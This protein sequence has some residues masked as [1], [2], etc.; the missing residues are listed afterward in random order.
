MIASSEI[1][2]VRKDVPSG[3]IILN[4]PDRRNALSSDMV[5]KLQEA[6]EDLH[7]ERSVR[8]IIL[9]GTENT[10]CAGTDL[11]EMSQL[12]EEPQAQE[13]WQDQVADLQ[14]LIEFMLRFP[15][16]IICAPN[17]WVVG[18]GLA[19]LLA[20]D[21]VVASDKTRLLLPEP[22]RGLVA[23]LTA[24]LLCHRVGAGRAAPLLLL[25]QELDAEQA[26]QMGIV[27]HVVEDRLLWFRSQEMA[28]EI[29]AF[30][31]ESIQLTK[32][33][34]NESIGEEV[35][36]QLSVGASDTATA[37]TTDAAG[38]GVNAFIQKRPP[39]WP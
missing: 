13:V 31:R 27:H 4:R 1:V 18:S 16:P 11:H 12:R 36:T 23:G 7:Q 33:L 25:G 20:C 37:R 34:M 29:A 15:K 24:P 2:H 22:R 17:G 38:E 35:F 30:S 19:L 10:F 26:R 32:R 39:K 28:K 21:L 5:H 3:T 8:A 14:A 6:F 9:S